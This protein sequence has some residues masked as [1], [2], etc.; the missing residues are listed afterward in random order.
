M[1]GE[2]QFGRFLRKDDLDKTVRRQYK[3]RSGR[4]ELTFFKNGSKM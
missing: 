3:G 1:T 4:T 2:K